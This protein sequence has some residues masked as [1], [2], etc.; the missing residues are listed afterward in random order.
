MRTITKNIYSF[1]ELSEEAREKAL[2]SWIDDFKFEDFF[3]DDQK[4][5]FKMFCQ[6]FNASWESWDIYGGVNYDLSDYR[7]EVKALSGIRLIK[8]VWNNFKK[9]LY[10]GKYYSKYISQN[11]FKYIHRYSK[12]ILNRECVLTGF[13]FDDDILQPI[14]GVI[15]GKKINSNYNFAD[16]IEDCMKEFIKSCESEME[17][18]S[19]QEY[20]SEHCE[21][22]QYE[23][24]ESGETV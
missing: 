10:K 20:Y 6:V 5:T 11:P 4:N 13:C 2:Q 23:F 14:Y 12:I 3:L 15:D 16:M 7:E 22:N 1:S 19:T 18:M 9:D 24:Y 8:Y 21:A 17:Y